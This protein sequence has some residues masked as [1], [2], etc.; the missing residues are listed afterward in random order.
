MAGRATPGLAPL[1][2]VGGRYCMATF[3][4]FSSFVFYAAI[5]FRD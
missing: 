3:G 2:I 1:T 5:A 4:G